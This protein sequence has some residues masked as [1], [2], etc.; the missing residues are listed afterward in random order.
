MDP[1]QLERLRR[2]YGS[3][4]G[5]EVIDPEWRK[6]ADRVFGP[7]GTRAKPYA[8]VPTLLAAPY[9]PLVVEAEEFGELDV[10]LIGVPM[11]LGVSNRTGA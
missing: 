1:K 10:A 2:K 3:T 11:D 7:G 5:G 8:G 4:H 9:R 6:V